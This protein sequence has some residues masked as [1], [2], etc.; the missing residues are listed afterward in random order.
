MDLEPAVKQKITN[1]CRD[2]IDYYNQNDKKN[3]KEISIADSAFISML[4][5]KH[6]E[7]S[8]KDLRICLL[9]KQNNSTSEIAHSIGIT[10]RGVE[11]MRYR[12]HK[13]LGLQKN[14][15][16]KNYLLKIAGI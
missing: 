7:L 16:I 11:S 2:L 9:I 6:P 12:L 13:K 3:D 5:R 15:S 14:E 10:T 8:K 4:Q 1:F